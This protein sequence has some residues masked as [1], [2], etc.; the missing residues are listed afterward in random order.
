MRRKSNKR[1]EGRR[2]CSRMRRTMRMN[3]KQ[4]KRGGG[5]QKVVWRRKRRS[6]RRIGG[7][8]KGR[9]GGEENRR[10]KIFSFN[11]TQMLIAGYFVFW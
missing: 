9:R 3:E 6:K 10:K 2:K 8:R 5:G 4:I 11:I 1:G 7:G